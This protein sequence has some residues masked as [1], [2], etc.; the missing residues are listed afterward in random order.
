MQFRDYSST[1][2]K[3]ITILPSKYYPDYLK[4]AT[5]RYAP[6]LT[7]FGELLEQ[8]TDSKKLFKLINEKKSTERIQL[9]RIFRKFV[10][11]DT[12]VE[13][14]KIKSKEQ[15]IIDEFGDKFRDLEEVK[16][17]YSSRPDP[18]ETLSGILKEYEDRG[19]KGYD[20]S[21]MFFNWFSKNFDKKFTIEGPVR[22]GKDVNLQDVFEDY[23]KIR[24]TDFLIRK[25]KVPV[26][27]GLIR[28]DSDRGGSQEDD[29]I[30]GYNNI[31]TE[32]V[33]YTE[34]HD[35][36][37]K[38]IFLNDGPGLLLGSM[39]NDYISLEEINISRIMVLTS[40]ML[41]SRFTSE[42]IDFLGMA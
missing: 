27:V 36:N 37:L 29:R 7:T 41:D 35:L 5:E 32:I 34:K 18:D 3:W 38:I 11:P 12:S 31:V 6:Y 15:I 30:S 42:W 19:Q 1:K 23:P 9:L 8:A 26:A 21:N 39:W 16:I 33:S 22:A 14:L 4:S 2:E 28:Y 20:I 10:S 24:P 13:M 40:K 25:N 17:Q